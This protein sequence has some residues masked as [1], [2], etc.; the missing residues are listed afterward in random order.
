MPDGPVSSGFHTPPSAAG[1]EGFGFGGVPPWTTLDNWNVD[2]DVPDCMLE[3]G[4]EISVAMDMVQEG[5]IYE[6]NSN[7]S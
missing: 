7:L 4:V 3:L 6:V 2:D 1:A 5:L